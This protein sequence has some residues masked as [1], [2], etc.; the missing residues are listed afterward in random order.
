[1]LRQSL[2]EQHP[3]TGHTCVNIGVT[4]LKLNDAKQGGKELQQGVKIITAGLGVGHPDTIISVK[5][6]VVLGRQYGGDR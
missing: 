1:L 2:G 6:L 5:E 4:Y 3:N